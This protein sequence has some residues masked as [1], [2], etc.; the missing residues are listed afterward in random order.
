[1]SEFT[2]IYDGEIER[3]IESIDRQLARLELYL[4]SREETQ[5][6][7]KQHIEETFGNIRQDIQ[8]LRKLM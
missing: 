7:E 6:Y 2:V 4:C 3:R 8:S 1:M 5:P